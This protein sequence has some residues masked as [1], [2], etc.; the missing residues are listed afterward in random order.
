MP[1]KSPY[2]IDIPQTNLLTYLFP[3][4]LEP[5]H[6][7]LWIN[8]RDT[9][10]SLSEALVLYW[11]KRLAVGLEQLGVKTTDIVMVFTPNHIFVPV[12]YLGIIGYG[13]IFSG[14]SSSSVVAGWP[15]LLPLA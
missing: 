8:A 5:S 11:I 9:S 14:V 13:A 2:V 6:D 3:S 7:S 12:V 10:I 15:I 1:Y 4:H